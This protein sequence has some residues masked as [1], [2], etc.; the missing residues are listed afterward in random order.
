MSISFSIEIEHLR[1][2]FKLDRTARIKGE[3]T[4]TALD[5]INMQVRPGELFGL[6]GPN[7]AGK[8]TLIRILCTLLTS[9]AGRATIDGLDIDK[10]MWRV[11]RIINMVSGGDT[12]GYGILTAIENLRLFTE[13]YGIPWKTAKPRIETMLKVVNLDRHRG[14]RINKLSTGMRQ[15][16]NFARG[17]ITN[18][19]VLF[20][21]EPTVGLDV[22][23]A[24]DIR[25][26]I[27]QWLKDH[28]ENTILLTTHYMAEADEICDRV[29]IIDQGRIQACDSPAA[30]K[31]SLQKE[32]ALELTI[33]KLDPLPEQLSKLTGV[34]RLA[35]QPE[36]QSKTTKIRALVES[37][38]VGGALIQAIS[39]NGRRLIGLHTIEPTLEDVFLKLTGRTLTEHQREEAS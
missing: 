35:A 15:R 1:R 6:L 28:P 2:V 30:L 4:L 19:K 10:D 11:R 14:V 36:D 8:T 39:M 20:L 32:T 22:H 24:R 25:K 12:C 33:D 23:S 16:M 9:T 3:K 37:P 13:L 34:I 17:F 18:P 26:F 38:E 31:K 27:V 5:D 21:D 7:G 29:A